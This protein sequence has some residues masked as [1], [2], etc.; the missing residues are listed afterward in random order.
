MVSGKLTSNNQQGS[1]D[2]TDDEKYFK[3]A[4]VIAEKYFQFPKPSTSKQTPTTLWQPSDDLMPLIAKAEDV[5]N[6]AEIPYPSNLM[7]N[8][9]NDNFDEKQLLQLVPKSK[10]NT[11]KYFLDQFD[12]RGNELTWN[13]SG[14]VFIDQTAIPQSNFYI[15]FPLLFKKGNPQNVIGFADVKKKLCDMGLNSY[16]LS[17]KKCDAKLPTKILDQNNDSEQNTPWWYI[18]D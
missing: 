15:I 18:G 14:V 4:S 16:L 17:K 7:N 13:S 6:K 5:K 3:I 1:G 10:K 2:V 12:A 11:A 8:D 9:F